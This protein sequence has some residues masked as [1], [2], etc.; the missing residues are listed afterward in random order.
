MKTRRF[1]RFGRAKVDVLGTVVWQTLQFTKTLM[2]I[3]KYPDT[4]LEEYM[5]KRTL[6]NVVGLGK[7]T[8]F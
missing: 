4:F 3:P 6:E 2:C 7:K 5:K 1:S 8:L